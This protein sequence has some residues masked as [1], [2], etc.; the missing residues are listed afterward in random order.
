MDDKHLIERC[1]NGEREVYELIVTKYQSMVFRLAFSITSSIEDARDIAQESFVRGFL[2]LSG[3]NADLNFKSWIMRITYNC[4]IDLIRKR[5]SFLKFFNKKVDEGI[6]RRERQYQL[7]SNSEIFS[8]H[9]KKL[10]PRERAILLMKYDQNLS[11]KEIGDILKCS[12]KT[13]RV[14]IFNARKKLK[15]YLEETEGN[16]GK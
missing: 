15:R 11:P 5:N 3:F 10:K 4:S 8:P 6:Q 9:M 13:I 2:N 7:V 16:D 12:P 14:H 1:L